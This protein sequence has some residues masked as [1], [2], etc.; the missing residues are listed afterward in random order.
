MWFWLCQIWVSQ[1]MLLHGEGV[2]AEQ[3]HSQCSSLMQWPWQK[4]REQ[5]GHRP[6]PPTDFSAREQPWVHSIY[7]QGCS[8]CG[9]IH[10]FPLHWIM[11]HHP[12]SEFLRKCHSTVWSSLVLWAE[13]SRRPRTWLECQVQQPLHSFKRNSLQLYLHLTLETVPR[14][15]SNPCLN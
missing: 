11:D 15:T 2:R 13:W 9:L 12:S 14:N 6:F 4:V 1:M 8:Q 10:W 3:D 5:N 7:Q